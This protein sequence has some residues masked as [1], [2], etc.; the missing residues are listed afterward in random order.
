MFAVAG[1]SPEIIGSGA[2]TQVP[3]GPAR[4]RLKGEPGRRGYSD[5]LSPM[6]AGALSKHSK[7]SLGFA[8]S[9]S[10]HSSNFLAR[11]YSP[12]VS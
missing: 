4:S 8:F 6:L 12:S 5:T 11:D 2:L 10:L 9:P 7:H 1:F 3:Q